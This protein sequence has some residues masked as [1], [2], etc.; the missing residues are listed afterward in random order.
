[1]QLFFIR[2][3]WICGIFLYLFI[4]ILKNRAP[5][6]S[7]K[8]HPIAI[9]LLT[10]S[11]ASLASLLVFAVKVAQSP[12]FGRVAELQSVANTFGGLAAAC[13]LSIACI[14][15]HYLRRCRTGF[16]RSE[17]I[18]KKLVT[19]TLTTG[20]LTS[21]CAICAL[22]ALA[23]APTKLVYILFFVNIS[24]LYTNSLL[25]TMNARQTIKNRLQHNT[26]GSSFNRYLSRAVETAANARRGS[27]KI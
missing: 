11:L 16:S 25:A 22:I 26:T 19:F 27:D 21:L 1:V 4:D 23:R 14:L 17:T 13:D 2:R 20:L 18:I 15:I 6:V 10:L 24:T 12:T 7:E 3:V 5:A 9:L 8:N